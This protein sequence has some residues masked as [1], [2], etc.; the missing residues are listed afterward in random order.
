MGQ[1]TGPFVLLVL[2]CPASGSRSARIGRRGSYAQTMLAF[3]YPRASGGVVSGPDQNTL[4]IA[5][6]KR[7]GRARWSSYT[8]DWC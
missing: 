6:G 2:S 4:L 3:P 5:L 1:A 8:Q 7:M